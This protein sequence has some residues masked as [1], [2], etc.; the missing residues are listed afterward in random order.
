M[1]K[2][3]FILS[4]LKVN[5]F[6]KPKNPGIGSRTIAVAV[7]LRKF[8]FSRYLLPKTLDKATPLSKAESNSTTIF[9]FS[10]NRN[11][12]FPINFSLVTALENGRILNEKSAARST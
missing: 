7:C 2:N 12:A 11:K 6:T 10:A 1:V 4:S 8:V 3:A 5:G 9:K